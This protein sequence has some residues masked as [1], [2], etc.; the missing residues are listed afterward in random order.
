MMALRRPIVATLFG[1]VQTL[2]PVDEGPFVKPAT[3][4]PHGPRS[5]PHQRASSLESVLEKVG[6]RREGLR[7][8]TALKVGVPVDHVLYAFLAGD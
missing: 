7:R 2:F 8:W 6:Y 5:N 3:L 1:P 4:G